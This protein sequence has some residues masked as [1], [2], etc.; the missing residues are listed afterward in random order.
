VRR[1]ILLALMGVLALRAVAAEHATR[2]TVD[3]LQRALAASEN[4]HRTDGEVAEQL[5]GMELTERLSTA[6][7]ARLKADLPG[8]KAQQALVALADSSVFLDPPDAEIPANP[9]PDA[10][11]LRQMLVSLVNYVNTTVRQLPNFMATRDTTRFEDR[12]LQDVQ[13]PVGMTTLIYLPLHV[14]GRSNVL[15]AYRDG[16]EVLE[17]V[18]EKSKRGESQ[19]RGLFTEGVFGPILSTVVGDALKGAITWSRWEEGASGTEAV[20]H[21][22]VPKEKAHYSVGFCC[23]AGGVTTETHESPGSYSLDTPEPSDWH[24]FAE[25]AAY[26]GEIAFDPVNGAILRITLEADMPPHEVVSKNGMMVEY[27]TVDIAGKSYICPLRGVSMLM[28]HST[29]PPLGMAHPPE[30][31]VSPTKTFL[32]DAVFEQYR[33]FGSET[34]IVSGDGIEA[35]GS[36]P[37]VVA[38]DSAS[39]QSAQEAKTEIA[40]TSAAPTAGDT[41]ATPAP[42]TVAVP[43]IPEEPEISVGAASDLGGNN[44]PGQPTNAA[45]DQGP[46]YTLKVTSRLV[47]VGI[48]AF[49]KK[50]HP[51]TDLKAQ[52]FEVYDNGVKQEI[53]FFSA[54]DVSAPAV[55]NAGASAAD[56]TFSNRATEANAGSLASGRTQG[57]ATIL[58]IDESHM[59]WPDLT[60]A[61]S[62][63]LD[64]LASAPAGERIGLYTMSSLG[65]RVLVEV[66][67]DHAALAATLKKWMPKAGSV[68]QA[69]NEE[70]RN[71]RQMDE[72]MHP[73]DLGSVNGN[74][75]NPPEGLSF[76]DPQLLTMGSNP[77][78]ASLIILVGVA[79][80]LAAVPGHKNLIWVSSD[81]VFADWGNQE[82]GTD[83]KIGSLDSFAL[84]AQEAMNDAHVA[85]YPFDVSQLETSAIAA[86]TQH[87][88]VQVTPTNPFGATIPTDYSGGRATAEMHQDIHPIQWPV[89]QVA[90]AT[91]GRA[92][93]R[94]GDLVGALS[95]IVED[96]HAIY[97]L[98]FSPSQ[99][100]DDKYHAI[101][102]KLSGKAHGLTLNYRTGYLYTKEPATLKERFQQAVWQPADANEV[103][104]TT[105]VHRME[106]GANM[107]IVIAARDLDL[108][109]Q[110]DR[111]MDRLDVFFVQRDDAG[112]RAQVE[113]QT[114]GLRLKEPT[115][116]QVL[117]TGIPYEHDV[118]LKKGVASLRIV[119][120]DKNSGRMGSVTIPVSVVDPDKQ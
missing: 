35:G 41:V 69:Q 62:Q 47:D 76:V 59:A 3:E 99:A 94:S 64:F 65:F 38:A 91:G 37:G 50:G 77:A 101:T 52:D 105:E 23:V 58:L 93:R 66:T 45:L 22:S 46:G 84:R 72:V 117:S 82:V 43:A 17:K 6:S 11:A 96:G 68:A 73:S 71:R 60:N 9:R 34:R 74:E 40:E 24:S 2:V 92:I 27:G 14:V 109:K 100:A 4:A 39:P 98:S 118:Q 80:R 86:D 19:E 75:A 56:A 1:L 7:L 67:T 12:P 112:V 10:A 110:A 104:V 44:Q 107:K 42:V 51:V 33:R 57:G 70:T 54:F 5:A 108:Q 95:E 89:R 83:R 49:D 106:Q 116:K 20:F 29:K 28:A 13:G 78:R 63:M 103:T 87:R 102:V 55:A 61:R 81:N 30:S 53:R 113:Q 36:A 26:H 15:V 90:E 119:V 111:W 85:V 115:Y 32:N 8:V 18:A 120:V 114:L 48:V 16:H 25:V 88:N 97:Q 79:R 31:Y 21:Y